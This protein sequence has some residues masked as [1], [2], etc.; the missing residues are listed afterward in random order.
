VD[1]FGHIPNGESAA[2][3]GSSC[4]LDIAANRRSA[5]EILNLK[6]GDP[7]ILELV[8]ESLGDKL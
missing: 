5:A 3:A 1:T 8:E 4:L 6:D 2:L 7:V